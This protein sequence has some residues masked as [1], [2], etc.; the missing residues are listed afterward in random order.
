MN[1]LCPRCGLDELRS[2]REANALSRK[3]NRTYVCSSCGTMEAMLDFDGEDVWP[4]FPYMLHGRGGSA[5][6]GQST[7]P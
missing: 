3:D 4:T 1:E 6:A 5:H 2:P 7:H